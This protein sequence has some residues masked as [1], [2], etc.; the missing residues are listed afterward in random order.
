MSIYI[1]YIREAT[2]NEW[3]RIWNNCDYSTYFHSREWSEV[4]NIYTNNKIKSAPQLIIFSDEIEAILPFSTKRIF[5]NFLIQ[6]ISS[7]AGTFGGWI[8]QDTLS[9]EHGQLLV[10][11]VYEKFGSVLLRLNPYDKIVGRCR[12]VDLE[13]D[14]T[15]AIN[16]EGRFDTIDRLWKKEHNSSYRK[17]R[18]ARNEGIIIRKAQCMEDWSKYFFIYEESIQRWGSHVSSRYEWKLFQILNNLNSKHTILWLATY[19]EKIIA[20]ALCFYSKNHVVYWHGA[21]LSEFFKMRPVNLLLYEI[22]KDACDRGF[23]WFDFNPSGGH[24]GVKSFKK[25][26][27]AIAIPSHIFETRSTIHSF[28]MKINTIMK[29]CIYSFK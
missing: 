12:F 3:D 8:S 7:P 5:Y 11:Y 29:L 17:A 10:D 28:F 2:P 16:L 27:G 23:S 24:E 20:G 14:E 26:F 21:A 13:Y 22:I 6:Y 18:K 19:E 9:I 25:S 4:W 1:R 15:H